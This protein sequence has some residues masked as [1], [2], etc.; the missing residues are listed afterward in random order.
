[1]P[2]VDGVQFESRHGDGLTLWA[3]FER[4]DDT[5]VSAHITDIQTVALNRTDPTFAEA[6]R[7]HN[8]TWAACDKPSP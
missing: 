8:L 5:A 6:F 3:I 2:L 1:V 7:L 4:D